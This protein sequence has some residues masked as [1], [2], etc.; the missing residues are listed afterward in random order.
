MKKFI[1]IACLCLHS[2]RSFSLSL[3][4]PLFSSSSIC[5]SVFLPDSRLRQTNTL[6]VSFHREG[7]WVFFWLY[8]FDIMTFWCFWLSQE[9]WIQRPTSFRPGTCHLSYV[10][11]PLW[12]RLTVHLLWTQA[13][14]CFFTSEDFLYFLSSSAI[15]FKRFCFYLV[16]FFLSMWCFSLRRFFYLFIFFFRT[17]SLS[18]CWK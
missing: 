12:L 13:L 18:D 9:S 14:H 4:S 5:S 8:P 1:E 15:Y 16:F 6:P 17:A 10:H 7:L 2:S 11:G 3:L